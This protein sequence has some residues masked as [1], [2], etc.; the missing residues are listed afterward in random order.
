MIK[1]GLEMQ[2]SVVFVSNSF[3]TPIIPVDFVACL[4]KL[5]KIDQ[6]FFGNSTISVK[7]R[8]LT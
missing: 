4:Q 6:S 2:V 3:L 5:G 1:H 7:N 8:K